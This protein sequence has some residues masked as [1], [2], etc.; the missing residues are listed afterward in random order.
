MEA[1]A[2]TGK[3]TT[4]K[5]AAAG[6]RGRCLYLAYNRAIAMDAAK[7]FPSK[8]E[9]RT[10]HSLAFRAL[11]ARYDRRL[12]VRVHT[13]RTAQLLRNPELLRVNQKIVLSPRTLARLVRRGDF[14]WRTTHRP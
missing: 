5:M 9:C 4:L 7:H 8:V 12:G 11:G 3:T 1:G 14:P 10:A 13:E 2:G 6:V